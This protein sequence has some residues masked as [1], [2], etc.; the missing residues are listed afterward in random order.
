MIKPNKNTFPFCFYNTMCFLYPV[1]QSPGLTFSKPGIQNMCFSIL[2]IRLCASCHHHPPANNSSNKSHKISF[3]VSASPLRLLQNYFFC[4]CLSSPPPI[5][6][7]QNVPMVAHSAPRFPTSNRSTQ[8]LWRNHN[9]S[10]TVCQ[11]TPAPPFPHPQ[12]L[13]FCK[14]QLICDPP[15]P[16]FLHANFMAIREWIWPLCQS[17]QVFSGGSWT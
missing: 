14:S 1:W 17:N 4:L 8:A 3:S 5:G 7:Q 9:P 13:L 16:L 6:S 12:L 15:P 2:W 10:S 11:H